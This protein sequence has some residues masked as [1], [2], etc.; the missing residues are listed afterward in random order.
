MSVERPVVLEGP[1]RTP[2]FA[3]LHEPDRPRQPRVGVSL[4]NPGLK[5]RVSPNRL[6]VRMARRLA[7]EGFFVLRLDPPG[8]G[9]SGGELPEGTL[10]ELWESIQ[11]GALVA[12]VEA[13]NRAFRETCG[14]TEVIGAG[15]C[16][17]A[18]TALL[19]C[20]GDPACRRLILMDA[21][22]TVKGADVRPEDRI[23][24]ARYGRWVLT[25]Y[26]RRLG[27]WRAW[28]RLFTF[29]SDL[30]TISRAL[31]AR[32]LPSK[33]PAAPAPGQAVAEGAEGKGE[34]LNEAFVEAFDAFEAR[35]GV[36]LFVN[37]EQDISLVHFESLFASKYMTSPERVAKHPRFV[38]KDANH[39]FGM[40]E[41]RDELLGIV[42]GWLAEPA[43][44]G[45]PPAT[46][47]PAEKGHA[48]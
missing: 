5:Y 32:F 12:P 31:R 28:V 7:N 29:R 2:M 35:G 13:A 44:T 41:W 42:S 36:V 21:P 23:R 4:L 18:V 11:R 30:A 43:G 48:S 25:S 24:D 33:E 46:A 19:A 38:V 9:D 1:G 34:Y 26:V 45:R 47:A 40:P 3:I 39:I 15:N 16:G 37:S 14:L 17:G 6:S 27:D 22:V 20:A 8:I 10:P